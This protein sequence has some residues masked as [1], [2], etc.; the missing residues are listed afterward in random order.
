M[1]IQAWSDQILLVELTE[2]P[3]LTEDLQ[4]IGH[5]IEN[6]PAKHVVLNLGGVRH[7]N[8]SHIS[9]LLRLRAALIN[10]DRQLRICNVPDMI[11]GVMLV[12]GLDKVFQFASDLPS[13]LASLQLEGPGGQKRSAGA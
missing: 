13:A 10:H 6:G 4:T 8:S 12:T 9:C 5:R 11:W 2:E 7:M 1:P 3:A